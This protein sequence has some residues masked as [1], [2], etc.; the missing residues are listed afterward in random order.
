MAK[1]KEVTE[2][3]KLL[4]LNVESGNAIIGKNRVVKELK[5][6][7]L[8]KVFLANNCPQNTKETINN[9]SEL[10]GIEVVELKVNNEELGIICKK[11]FFVSIVGISK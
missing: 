9:L 1:K 8:Q 4:K 3:I 6:S 10:S 5:K 11:N 2:E 7:N